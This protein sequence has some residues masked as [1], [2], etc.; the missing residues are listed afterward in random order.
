MHIF[1]LSQ[2]RSLFLVWRAF[3]LIMYSAGGGTMNYYVE[4]MANFEPHE[5]SSASILRKKLK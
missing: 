3:F 5:K 2:Q 4:K 1:F